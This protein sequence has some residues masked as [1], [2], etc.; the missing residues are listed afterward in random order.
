MN[1]PKD[2]SLS[3][4]KKIDTIHQLLEKTEI[5]HFLEMLEVKNK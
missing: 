1:F 5:K 4:K 2:C 3:L